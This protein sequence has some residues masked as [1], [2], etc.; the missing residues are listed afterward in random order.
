MADS[1]MAM[2]LMYLSASLGATSRMGLLRGRLWMTGYRDTWDELQELCC[3]MP[4]PMPA[5]ECGLLSLLAAPCLCG[6]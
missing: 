2:G 6:T 1:P 5:A 4:W 3:W